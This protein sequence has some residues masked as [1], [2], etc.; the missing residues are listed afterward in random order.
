DPVL[1]EPVPA[2][3]P[4][5]SLFDCQ[6]AGCSHTFLAQESF[7]L[8]HELSGR[9][10]TVLGL[11]GDVGQSGSEDIRLSPPSGG[12]LGDS[13]GWLPDLPVVSEDSFGPL[14]D[15]CRTASRVRC[16]ANARF[17]PSPADLFSLG[18]VGLPDTNVYLNRISSSRRH[19]PR[20][21]S[22]TAGRKFEH[23]I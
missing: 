18:R 7:G 17:I 12:G 15:P 21:V 5:Q 20:S 6:D 19:E 10:E 11:L 2:R 1:V 9:D 13:R 14:D 3:D 22:E 23:T 4:A 16:V 8:Q